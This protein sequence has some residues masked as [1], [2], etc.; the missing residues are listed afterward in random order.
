MPWWTRCDLHESSYVT[1]ALADDAK[2]PCEYLVRAELWKMDVE[3][4]ADA[5]T[6]LALPTYIFSKIR[7]RQ[8]SIA[9]TLNVLCSNALR[10]VYDIAPVRPLRAT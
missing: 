1:A 3:Y 6:Q 7:I 5:G 10:F 9:N 4:S 8:I 2:Q